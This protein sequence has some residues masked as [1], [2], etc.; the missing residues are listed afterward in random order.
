MNLIFNVKVKV[1][2]YSLLLPLSH[3]TFQLTPCSRGLSTPAPSQ[4]HGEHTSLA[5]VTFPW[6]SIPTCIHALP[7]QAPV[8]A[9]TWRKAIYIRNTNMATRPEFVSRTLS[10]RVHLLTTWPSGSVFMSYITA[11]CR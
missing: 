4:L 2:V 9:P 10:S 1:E 11:K 7:L 6:L 5:T 8:Y 3:I